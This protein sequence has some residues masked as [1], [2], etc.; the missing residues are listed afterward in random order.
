MYMKTCAPI[1][2]PTSG[3]GNDGFNRPALGKM[4]GMPLSDYFYCPV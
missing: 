4:S 2:I 1:H 3:A